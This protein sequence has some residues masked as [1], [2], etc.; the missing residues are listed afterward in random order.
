MSPE[1]ATGAQVDS[2]SDVFAMGAVLYEMVTGRRAFAGSSTEE[3]L[4]AVVRAQPKTPSEV[5]A[6]VPKELDR[7][8]QRCLRKEPDRRFQHMLD[9]KLELEQIKEDSD[10]Q[11]PVAPVAAGRSR[12]RLV[13]GA[14]LA[15]ALVLGAAAWRIG[16]APVVALPAPRLV[17]LT[18]TRGNEETPTFSPDGDQVAF[19]WNGEKS[20]SPDWDIAMDIYVKMAGSSETHRLTTDPARD[21]CPSWSPDGR[22]I[23][24]V[25]GVPEKDNV[26]MY[27]G[28]I[29]V[30]SPLGGSD[31]KLSD[32][33]VG[34]YNCQ[35][36]WS[37]DGRWLA[38][39]RLGTAWLVA[40]G[41]GSA[42][43]TT[44]DDGGIFLVPAQGG[45]P[46]LLVRAPPSGTNTAPAFS[47]DGRSLGYASCPPVLPCDVHVVRL[48]SDLAPTSPPR[49]LTRQGLNISSL[50]WA[51]DGASIVYAGGQGAHSRLWRVAVEG[52]RPPE[53]IE[54]AGYRASS[55]AIAPAGHRLAFSS[56][57]TDDDIYRFD[58]PRPSRV[59]LGSSFSEV[60]PVFSPD[61]RRILFNS[62]RSGERQ[63][64][65][66]AAADGSNP[67]QLTR[68]PGRE[69]AAASWSPDSR[70]IAFES[71]GEDG[72]WHI[73]TI[74]A[75]GG[76][77]RRLTLDL[78]DENAPLWSGDGRWVYFLSERDGRNAI[79]RIPAS[80]GAE[81]R[82]TE[83]GTG[84]KLYESSD[85][86]AL[87]FQ[88]SEPGR[89]LLA[90]PLAGGP[91]RTLVKCAS[92][93]TVGAGAIYYAEC[94]GNPTLHRLDPATGQDRA[95]GR[96]EKF[97]GSGSLAVSPDGKTILFG[98]AVGNGSDL[99][100]IE[101]FE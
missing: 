25:R 85:G 38:A 57:F 19:A 96:L 70:R 68:G 21:V 46:R 81:E 98:K 97:G 29:R 9:V 8:I 65:W 22:Q 13:V 84:P 53:R 30:V 59:F 94:D 60:G 18:T 77:P 80:G 67:E 36:S 48:G 58:P 101:N 99:M 76:T 20:D 6:G 33:P 93:F 41:E 62:F 45:E 17:P 43:P 15:V 26:F 7:L 4:A 72:H 86:K 66:L 56:G 37:P 55:V 91:D 95:L 52:D 90:W 79:W 78:G 47:P 14:A 61:G 1:Q 40:A 42:S 31:R 2:R 89:A 82:V 32:L 73:W 16:R 83:R 71:Q 27:R 64:I 3:T 10:S 28:R 49:R 54:L 87:F 44:P 50:Q 23:A 88:K 63:E 51:R 24:F 12:R 75:E 35:L 74:D 34:S 39:A 5:V 69:Q 100:M 11:A 92:S